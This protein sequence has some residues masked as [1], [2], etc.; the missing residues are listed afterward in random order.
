MLFT[1]LY[2]CLFILSL[3]H[4]ESW[5]EVMDSTL[6][7][8]S[9]ISCHRYC[10]CTQTWSSTCQST[11]GNLPHSPVF[12]VDCGRI[13]E[14][15]LAPWRLNQSQFY[16]YNL[17]WTQ[18]WEWLLWSLLCTGHLTAF[19]NILSRGRREPFNIFVRTWINQKTISCSA[20]MLG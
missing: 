12:F 6:S 19:Y 10:T 18:C 8:G 9:Q 2:I 17:S 1:S 4:M 16:T 13:G 15:R 11:A 20:R 14:G 3:H 7:V 5:G